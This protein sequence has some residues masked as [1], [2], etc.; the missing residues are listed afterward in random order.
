MSNAQSAR[1]YPNEPVWTRQL[2]RF[3]GRLGEDPHVSHILATIHTKARTN[4]TGVARAFLLLSQNG[5]PIGEPEYSD[6]GKAAPR[7]AIQRGADLV[8]QAEADWSTSTT[9]SEATATVDEH[10]EHSQD[11]R[12]DWHVLRIADRG[13]VAP[14]WCLTYAR[15]RVHA[16]RK[17]SFPAAST[18]GD[19][20]DVSYIGTWPVFQQKVADGE[21]W[22][23]DSDRVMLDREAPVAPPDGMREVMMDA[24]R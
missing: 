24:S 4:A 18:W 12:Y 6:S 1:F 14:D 7:P 3:R 22:S 17:P 13:D 21:R 11:A 20:G 16:I 2:R 8:L 15:D 9:R 19:R 23:V 5:V 10:I